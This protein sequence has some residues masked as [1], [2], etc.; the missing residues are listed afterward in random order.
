MAFWLDIAGFILKALFIVAA[1]GAL[2]ALIARLTRRDTARGRE[3]E[4]HSLNE[5]YDQM[6]DELDAEILDRKEWRSLAKARARGQARPR[7]TRRPPSASAS[8]CSAS[9]AT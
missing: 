3:I 2:A 8:M 7:P 4:V 6:R 9:R 5:R 1:L